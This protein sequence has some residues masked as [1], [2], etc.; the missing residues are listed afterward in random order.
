MIL[1]EIPG[2]EPI[3]L[4]NLVIDY[5]GTLAID[6]M[7]LPGVA[8]RLQILSEK[9][10]IY[11]VTA[12]TFGRVAKGLEGLPCE[13]VILQPG[14]QDSKKRLFVEQLGSNQTA[15]IGNG[16]NDR[17][18]LQDA[19]LGIVVVQ[20]EC[21]STAAITAADITA[22]SILDALDLFLNPM[23]MMATLRV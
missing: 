21:A 19:V 15:C 13:L 2:D 12:D 11:V 9:L 4:K 8:D 14:A 1:I 20:G 16:R 6:G 18:M 10:S 3:K 5:N 23:R 22:T 7:L 17:L